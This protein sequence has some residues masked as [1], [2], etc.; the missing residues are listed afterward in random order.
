VPHPFAF[1]L[2]KGWETTNLNRPRSKAAKSKD[3]RFALARF[4]LRRP[5]GRVGDQRRSLFPPKAARLDGKSLHRRWPKAARLD[6][7]P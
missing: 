3:L 1:F 6:S 7:L 5:P 4:C 2:A